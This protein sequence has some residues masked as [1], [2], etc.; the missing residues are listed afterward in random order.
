MLPHHHPRQLCVV[1]LN[2]FHQEVV[3]QASWHHY[4][5]IYNF[6][7]NW[8]VYTLYANSGM[9]S[10]PLQC[11]KHNVKSLTQSSLQSLVGCTNDH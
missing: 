4:S 3:I 9:R 10:I 8:D 11:R 1:T 7:L 2:L 6:S 5:M